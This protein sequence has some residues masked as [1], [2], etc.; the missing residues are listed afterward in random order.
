METDRDYL[1]PAEVAARLRLSIRS[2]YRL[3][4]SGR[5]A[6]VRRGERGHYLVTPAAADAFLQAPRGP[7]VQPT[8]QAQ[9][10][11]EAALEK[12]RAVGYRC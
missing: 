12:L 3:L 11:H 10:E 7:A 9:Q 2:V 6:S 8:R 4:T 1:T 5:I